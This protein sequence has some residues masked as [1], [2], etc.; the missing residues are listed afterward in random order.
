MCCTLVRCLEGGKEINQAIQ[1]F[2]L[3]AFP[4]FLNLPKN[5][6]G[7]TA[8][9]TLIAR[10]RKV[11]LMALGTFVLK[12]IFCLQTHWATAYRQGDQIGRFFAQCVNVCFGQL[13]ENYRN[14]PHF[15]AT[16]FNG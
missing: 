15:W 14:S 11:V 1:N 13:H 16:L 3:S 6:S 8:G 12:N 4:L 10:W 2:Q 9:C 7:T 5:D